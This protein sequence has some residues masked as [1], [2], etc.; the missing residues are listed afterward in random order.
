MDEHNNDNANNDNNTINND[1][2]DNDKF[3]FDNYNNDYNDDDYEN[4]GG[5]I[6]DDD[7]DNSNINNNNSNIYTS[8]NRSGLRIIWGFIHHI[9]WNKCM[10]KQSCP[11]FTSD[12]EMQDI[13]ASLILNPNLAKI[14][15]SIV[16]SCFDHYH[17]CPL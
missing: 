7:N 12:V 11:L 9:N 15:F 6:D 16:K 3:N 8:T 17:H 2:Y 14:R 4:D 5:D 13:P 1:N 10:D